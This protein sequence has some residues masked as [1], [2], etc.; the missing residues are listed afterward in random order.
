MTFESY[1]DAFPHMHLARQDGVLSIRLHSSQ[2]PLRWNL[3][4]QHEFGEAFKAIGADSGNRV[5]VLTGTGDEFSGPR[6]DP[7]VHGFFHDAN[8]TPSGAAFVFRNG[9]KLL[10]SILDVEVPIIAAVNGP[11]MRHSDL[12]LVSDIV[13]AADHATFEDT[14]HF[15]LGGI[16]PGD[17]VS[18]IY[19]MLLGLN[20]A[21]YML[22]TGEIITAQKALQL[23]LVSEVLPLG[24]LMARAMHLAHALAAKP[25]MLLRNTRRVLIH[26]LKKALEE[27]LDFFLSLEFL[28]VLDMGRKEPK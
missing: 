10:R 21:R 15:H 1:R 28:A 9:R 19:S 26:P 25:D 12:A 5:I 17:G 7:N 18:T 20:R 14:A 27:D 16:V 3:D 6:V 23:G 2:G 22:L 24:E 4:A 8:L 13:I 11:A